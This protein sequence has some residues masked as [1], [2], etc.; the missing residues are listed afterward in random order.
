MID[1]N[2][3][4][5]CCGDYLEVTIDLSDNVGIQVHVEPCESCKQEARDEGYDEGHIEGY[6]EGYAQGLEEGVDEE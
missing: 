4:C 6:D 3:V 2:A 5:S 1:I